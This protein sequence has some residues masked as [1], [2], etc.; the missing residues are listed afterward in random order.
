[1]ELKQKSIKDKKNKG[2][3]KFDDVFIDELLLFP[4]HVGLGVMKLIKDFKPKPP[5]MKGWTQL[6]GGVV[7]GEIPF[8]FEIEYLMTEKNEIIYLDVMEIT[9]DDYL[10][11]INLNKY[12]K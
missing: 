12:L 2:S 6:I 7:K 1:M 10:D 5:R 11:Y 3:L 4:Y 9:C 8:F